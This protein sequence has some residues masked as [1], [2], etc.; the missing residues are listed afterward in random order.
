MDSKFTFEQLE[1]A[2]ADFLQQI[3][4]SKVVAFHG[5]MGAGKTTFILA[6]CKVLGVVDVTSSP[7]FSIINQYKTKSGSVVYH[8]DL[9]RLRNEQEAVMA[10]VE[11][12]FYS[13]SLSLVEWPEKAPDIFPPDTVHCYLTAISNNERKLQ[14]KL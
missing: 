5:E 2:A 6:I 13:G 9:Y 11:D 4:N 8:M 12:C 3:G 14:I 7:T 10:G 1:E